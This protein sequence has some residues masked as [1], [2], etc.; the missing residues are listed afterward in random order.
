MNK[1]IIFCV[2]DG[3]D[4]KQHIDKRKGRWVV[5]WGR[6]TS[7]A[8]K[9]GVIKMFRSRFVYMTN[10]NL[11]EIAEGFHIHHIDF[12]RENDEIENLKMLSEIDHYCAHKS[13]PSSFLGR[14]HSEESIDLMKDIASKRGNN[15]VWCGEKKTHS[16]DTK[17]L[18]SDKSIGVNNASFRKD[19]DAQEVLK[20]FS[21]SNNLRRTAEKFGCSCSV[22][23]RVV[24]GK[25]N[26]SSWR[27]LSDA[28]LIAGLDRFHGNVRLLA[29]EL[30][31]PD[32]SLWRKINKIKL[33][34]ISSD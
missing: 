16:Q 14:R 33:E 21:M 10:N 30:S 3:V 7:L 31:A 13:Q 9:Y 34:G 17:L 18:M 25:C 24:E 20:E 32:T 29:K 22:V 26:T 11:I 4:V 27:L 28:D 23:R 6:D 5:R 15:G 1:D 12:N 19:I 2:V 8:E